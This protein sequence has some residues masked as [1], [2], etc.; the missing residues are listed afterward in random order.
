MNKASYLFKLYLFKIKALHL[1][2]IFKKLIR[3]AKLCEN[4]E[5][6]KSNVNKNM[7][8]HLLCIKKGWSSVDKKRTKK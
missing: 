1:F 4:W 6:T 3:M 5:K 7:R 8:V 2:K